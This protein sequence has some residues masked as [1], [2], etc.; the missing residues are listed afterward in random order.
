MG[1]NTLPFEEPCG[2]QQENTGANGSISPDLRCSPAKPA[3]DG[4]VDLLE[5]RITTDQESINFFVTI[6]DG[7]ICEK[8]NTPGAPHRLGGCCYHLDVIGLGSAKPPSSLPEDLRRTQDGERLHA[9]GC[10]YHYAHGRSRSPRAA[11][12]R[13]FATSVIN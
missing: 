13:R 3:N 12:R 4:R 7:A 9:R 11:S 6:V 8:A 10:K 5:R 2:G 1:R